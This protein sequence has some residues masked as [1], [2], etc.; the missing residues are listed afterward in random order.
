MPVD[1]WVRGNQNVQIAGVAAGATIQV[2]IGTAAPVRLPLLRAEVPVGPGCAVPG[3]LLRARAGVLPFVD[4]AGLVSGLDAWMGLPEWF[5]A[6]VVGGRGGSGKTRLGVHLCVQAG[7]RG[8]VGGLLSTKADPA[9]VA[10]LAHLQSPRLVVVDYAEA[11]A[12][13]LEVL[14]PFLAGQSTERWPVRV[15][16]LVRSS[17]RVG[18]DWAAPLR[19]RRSEEL[20]QI[21]DQTETQVLDDRHRVHQRRPRDDPPSR[22]RTWLP[23][24]SSGWP[25]AC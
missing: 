24:S 23:A 18:Q 20:D 4:R 11:R 7:L 17:A 2:S 15:L 14:L 8:W 13:Q 3:R 21:L 25:P 6:H 12:E 19:V 16:L 9:E 1:Q 5:A 10:A 22:S